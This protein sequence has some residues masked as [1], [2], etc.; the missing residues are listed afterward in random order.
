MQKASGSEGR[1][2]TAGKQRIKSN[3]TTLTDSLNRPRCGVTQCKPGE[4]GM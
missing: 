3:Y 2:Y 4:A 1:P